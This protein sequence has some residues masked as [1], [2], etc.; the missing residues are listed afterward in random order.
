MKTNSKFRIAVVDD[1][2][3]IGTICVELLQA[4][5]FEAVHFPNAETMLGE[6][7]AKIDLLITDISL[8]LGGM[9]GIDLASQYNF[10]LKKENLPSVPVLF[11]SGYGEKKISTH[12]LKHDQIHFLEKPFNLEK[13]LA[14]IRNILTPPKSPSAPAA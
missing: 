10:L 8:G 4:Q 6:K 5:G 11:M 12:F 13:L 7:I 14:K 1:E 3:D 9:S 2:L